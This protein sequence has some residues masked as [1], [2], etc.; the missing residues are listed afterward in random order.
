MILLANMEIRQ[1]LIRYLIEAKYMKV[2]LLA[3]GFGSRISEES[4]FKPK[5]MIE[6]GGMPI[7]WHIMKIY[8]FGYPANKTIPHFITRKAYIVYYNLPTSVNWVNKLI[9]ITLLKYSL[10]IHIST[11]F[12]FKL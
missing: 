3:G 9:A 6:I 10:I 11:I 5:P 12:S 1:R 8:S 4:Q 2:V 7:L